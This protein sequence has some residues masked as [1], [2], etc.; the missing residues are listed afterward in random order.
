[1]AAEGVG[2]L[3]IVEAVGRRWLVALLVAL[4][5]W[6]G[7]IWYS[8]S[9]PNLYDGTA[10]VAF[11]PTSNATASDTIRVLVPKYV[12]YLSSPATARDVGQRLGED[13]TTLA[14]AVNASV[15]VDTANLKVV[16][17]LPDPNRAARAA[18]AFAQAAIDLSAGD[19]QLTATLL[20]P[21]L[22]PDTPASPPRKLLDGGGLVLAL[23]GGVTAALVVDRNRPR[24]ID[25]LSLALDSG[26][27]TVGRLPTSRLIKKRGPLEA[28]NDPALGTAVRAMRTQLEQQ[29]RNQPVKVV[30]VTSP[31]SGDG[32]TTVAVALAAS[33]ARV[34]ASVLLMDA[35]MRRPRLAPALRLPLAGP[36]LSDVL[37]GLPL[38]QAVRRTSLEGLSAVVTGHREDAGDALARRMTAV[39]AEARELYDVIVIDCP[40][41]LAT[42]DARTL[43]LVA[44]GTLLVVESGSDSMRVAE[45]AGSLDS[46]GV[47]VLGCVLNRARL[48]RREGLGTYG[49]YRSA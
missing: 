38:S 32:K 34:D 25:A 22:V 15:A 16:V 4:P 47:R 24:V 9:L 39:L 30:A 44:D 6:G 36:G 31:A 23:V 48:S 18:N 37:D 1:M 21:A 13:Q 46:L 11:S 12:A 7:V 33:L 20:A 40:P 28:L 26:H 42:D 10:L 27:G 14:K 5:L 35:D 49:S 2:L 45:A 41:L 29:S 3:D 19:K 43:A 17:R 8:Q